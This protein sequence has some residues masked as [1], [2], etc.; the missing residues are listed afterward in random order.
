MKANASKKK[1]PTHRTTTPA[2]NRSDLRR[3][4]KKTPPRP[5]LSEGTSSSIHKPLATTSVGGKLLQ[6]MGW[7]RG[8]GLGKRGQGIT[9]PMVA[10]GKGDGEYGGLGAT[11][12]MPA[13]PSLSERAVAKLKV[14]FVGLSSI[15]RV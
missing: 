12:L 1:K 15:T 2:H 13:D 9:E 4:D 10:I 5:I 3:D 8:E 14:G 7:K 6:K 11:P